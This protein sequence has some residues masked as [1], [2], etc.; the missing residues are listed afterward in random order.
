VSLIQ[1]NA[2]GSTV[3]TVDDPRQVSISLYYSAG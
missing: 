1:I 2:V 3:N